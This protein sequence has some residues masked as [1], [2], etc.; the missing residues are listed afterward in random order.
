LLV[1]YEDLPRAILFLRRRATI[2]NLEF[3]K[4]FNPKTDVAVL[5]D[6]SAIQV[7]VESVEL[8]SVLSGKR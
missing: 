1:F 4:S 8:L 6:G 5:T 2:L 7:S 3:L